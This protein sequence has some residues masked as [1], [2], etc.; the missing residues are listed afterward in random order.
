MFKPMPSTCRY[1]KFLLRLREWLTTCQIRA[2]NSSASR[3]SPRGT[4][5]VSFYVSGETSSDVA[6]LFRIRAPI[7]GTCG[8]VTVT[9]TGWNTNVKY[10]SYNSGDRFFF[11][12]FLCNNRSI[13]K[14]SQRFP[15]QLGVDWRGNLSSV[16]ADFTVLSSQDW[17]ET[18]YRWQRPALN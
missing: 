8:P 15:S 18:T 5:L 11:A 4:S 1:P 9:Q 12:L 17:L 7:Q 6:A 10:S 14:G 2:T 3:M 13:H 16:D